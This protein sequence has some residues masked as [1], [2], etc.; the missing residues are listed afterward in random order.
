[1]QCQGLAT[2]VANLLGSLTTVSA[3]DLGACL[4]TH[5]ERETAVRHAAAVVYPLH[6]ERQTAHRQAEPRGRRESVR[7][8][9]TRTTELTR[10]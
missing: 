10:V 2:G 1:V 8:T 5:T 9:A 4:P 7:V 6:S 3:V